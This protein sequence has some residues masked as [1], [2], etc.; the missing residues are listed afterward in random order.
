MT[1]ID[2]LLRERVREELTA[3]YRRS[4]DVGIGE[5]AV[6]VEVDPPQERGPVTVR[7]QA[8]LSLAD[9]RRVKRRTHVGAVHGHAPRL[10]FRVEC[11]ARCDKRCN[12]GD[13]VPDPVARAVAL[14]A[15]GLVEVTR[16]CRVDRDQR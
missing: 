15:I 12:I 3:S 7:Q 1:A 16:A 10:C 13:R 2:A 4:L 5:R 11:A 14:G 9:D 6:V 8:R